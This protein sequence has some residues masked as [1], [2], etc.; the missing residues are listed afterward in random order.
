MTKAI[1]KKV[2]KSS[3]DY[4]KV[5]VKKP[6]GYEYLMFENGT[7]GVTL[8]LL[9]AYSQGGLAGV[10]GHELAHWRLHHG[11][12]STFTREEHH[13]VEHEA[14]LAAIKVMTKAG[15]DPME[16]IAALDS[17]DD[18]DS[19]THP[20]KGDRIKLIMAELRKE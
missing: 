3:V 6:W 1:K 8:G 18:E 14:D 19:Y 11:T 15:Y 12:R 9:M 10:L 20:R 13:K 16:Y 17:L 4:H 5:V 7:V 2:K